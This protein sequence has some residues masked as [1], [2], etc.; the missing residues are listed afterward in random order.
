MSKEQHL[1][2]VVPLLEKEDELLDTRRLGVPAVPHD[3]FHI[4]VVGMV[5]DYMVSIAYAGQFFEGTKRA[6]VLRTEFV[7]RVSE[8]SRVTM[9][10][11]KELVI[12][13]SRARRKGR[14]ASCLARSPS[15]S[16]FAPAPHQPTHPPPRA[17]TN[18]SL[19][20]QRDGA[21]RSCI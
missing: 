3:N 10:K 8:A 4:V 13:S 5:V 19:H 18:C 12:H 6:S 15:Q 16:Y 20:G 9:R 17:Q 2:E 21:G 7:S 11:S 1:L 14:R